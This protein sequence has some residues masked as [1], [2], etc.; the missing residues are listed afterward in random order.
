MDVGLELLQFFLLCDAEMLLLVDDEQSEMGEPDV[1]GEQRVRPDDDVEQAF[2][3]LFFDRA[4]V[5]GAAL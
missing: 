3:E 1:L 5:L 4:R 2:D